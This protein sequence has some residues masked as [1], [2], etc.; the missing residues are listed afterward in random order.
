MKEYAK[1]SVGTDKLSVSEF[2]TFVKED[3][4]ELGIPIE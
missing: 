4:E 1:A 2:N 3:A